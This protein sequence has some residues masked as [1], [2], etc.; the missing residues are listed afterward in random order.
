MYLAYG[1]LLPESNFTL[2]DAQRR[3]KERFPQYSLSTAANQITIASKDW[4]IEV[5]LLDSPQIALDSQHLAEKLVGI[6]V[7]AVSSCAR[8]VEVW[9]NTPDPHLEHFGDYQTVIEVM[10]NFTGVIAVDPKEPGLL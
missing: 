2:E 9:S 10:K 5:A 6:D 8:R 7:V 1:L 3:L 4:A